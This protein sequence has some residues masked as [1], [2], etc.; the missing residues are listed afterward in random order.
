MGVQAYQGFL[1]FVHVLMTPFHQK[2]FTPN[3]FPVDGEMSRQ[4]IDPVFVAPAL[5]WVT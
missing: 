2:S 5:A 3:L 4:H 1:L